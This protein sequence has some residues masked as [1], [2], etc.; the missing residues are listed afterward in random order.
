MCYAAQV[1]AEF[2][3]FQRAFGAVMDLKT[4]VKTCWW[5][6]GR[7]PM[8]KALAKTPR[9]MIRELR[10][11]V[12]PELRENLLEAD[13]ATMAALEEELFALRR[14]VADAQRAL[15]IKPTKKAQ[16][17]V[18][19]G[20]NKSSAALCSICSPGGPRCDSRRAW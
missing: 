14:R 9:A 12:P 10:Q 3:Q 13:A 1:R 7:D 17:D 6:R 5:E 18:R 19:I 16:E 4:C 15:A 8:R 2:K 20:T 11:I